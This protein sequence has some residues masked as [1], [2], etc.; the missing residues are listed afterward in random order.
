MY[1]ISHSYIQKHTIFVI[2]WNTY[3]VQKGYI[4]QLIVYE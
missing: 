3:I 4:C 1:K 2:F